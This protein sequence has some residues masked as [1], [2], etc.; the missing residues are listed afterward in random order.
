MPL[1]LSIVGKSKS[2]KTTLI[3]K[4][5]SALKSRGYRVATVKHTTHREFADK[6][7]K[8]SWRHIQAGS[9]ATATSSPDG[10]V[11]V[12]PTTYDP[13]LEEI[14]RLFNED[15]DIVI[16]EGFKQCDA[17]KIEVHRKQIGAPLCGLKNLVAVVTDEPLQ[18]SVRQFQIDDI[19]SLTDFVES[20]LI[21]SGNK[22][23]SV[24]VNSVP[25]KLN[26]TNQEMIINTLIAMTSNADYRQAIE[27]IDIS[28]KKG[29]S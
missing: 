11:L 27:I 8:D 15:Y 19:E 7:G 22:R 23:I 4:L 2:G 12:K 14:T 10:I 18:S 24:Y 9:E 29:I 26:A 3:E 20:N 28:Y 21:K 1:T 25:R 16:A 13:P 17:P 5:V 6:P